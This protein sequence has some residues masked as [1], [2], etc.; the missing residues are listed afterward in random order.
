MALLEI[1]DISKTYR[2]GEIQVHALADINL[3]LDESE[4]AALVGPS[5]SGKTTLLNIIGGLD[6]PSSGSVLLNGTDLT[7]MDEAALSN[8]RLLEVT[9]FFRPIIWCRS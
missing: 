2:Q 4:F 5:G 9:L 7:T 6:V 8:F 1:K 3:Q